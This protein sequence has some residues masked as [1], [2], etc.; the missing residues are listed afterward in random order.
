MNDDQRKPRT[1]QQILDMIRKDMIRHYIEH[2]WNGLYCTF[3][4]EEI[5]FTEDGHFPKWDD[6][7]HKESCAFPHMLSVIN[8]YEEN[9]RKAG[10]LDDVPTETE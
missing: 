2:G 7:Q 1:Y 8:I 9:H 4:D 6:L 5:P 3:C 10:T